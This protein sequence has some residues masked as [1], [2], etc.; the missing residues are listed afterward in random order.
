MFYRKITNEVTLS[1]TIPQ[2]AQPLFS[3]IEAHRNWLGQ[4]LTW[5]ETVQSPTDVENFIKTL[6]EI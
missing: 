1:L 6:K 3:L 4:W 2:Y 5:P